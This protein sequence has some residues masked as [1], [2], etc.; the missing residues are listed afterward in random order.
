MNY[1]KPLSYSVVKHGI[2]GIT[3]YYAASLAS[4]NIRVNCLSPGGIYNKQDKKFVKKIKQLIPLNRMAN[5]D[6]YNGAIVFMCGDE[7]KYMT[8]HNLIIDG[9]RSII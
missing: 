3:K 5:F 9:G 6:E 4:Y 8:G 1:K 2:L 7:S